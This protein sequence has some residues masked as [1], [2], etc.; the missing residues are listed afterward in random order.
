MI[1]P[2]GLFNADAAGADSDP[3]AQKSIEKLTRKLKHK[4]TEL[5]QVK[6][7]LLSKKNQVSKAE[8]AQ[9]KMDAEIRETQTKLTECTEKL[10]YTTS[11]LKE[12]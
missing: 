10:N 3:K 7:D 9:V 12:L 1:A 4:E 2:G 5:K 8:L 6:S 11:R